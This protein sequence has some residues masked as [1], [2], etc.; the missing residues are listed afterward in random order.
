MLAIT[1]NFKVDIMFRSGV[2]SVIAALCLSLVWA[3][4]GGVGRVSQQKSTDDV[5]G[6]FFEKEERVKAVSDFQ[7]RMNTAVTAEQMQSIV[8][9]YRALSERRF[10]SENTDSFNP[11]EN[12]KSS[13]ANESGHSS[14]EQSAL[15]EVKQEA[16]LLSEMKAQAK[17][18]PKLLARLAVAE[19]RLQSIDRIKAK[20][21]AAN[22]ATGEE[23]QILFDEV[24][25]EQTKMFYAREIETNAQLQEVN[26]QEAQDSRELPPEMA[27]VKDKSEAHKHEIGQLKEALSKV[28]PEERAKLLDIWRKKRQDEIAAMRA[29]MERAR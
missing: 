21:V 2:F 8:D 16:L 28:S 10:R 9:D 7:Q 19:E 13:I 6:L 25:L 4:Q 27:E 26:V 17:E 15:I 23:K 3:D 24:R 11:V 22:G 29:Q 5:T 14:G 12:S 1:H 18:N 20:L